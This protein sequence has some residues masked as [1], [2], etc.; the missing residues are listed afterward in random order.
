MLSSSS[1]PC[2]ERWDI[3]KGEEQDL[4]CSNALNAVSLDIRLVA[5]LSSTIRIS[6]SFELYGICA[7]LV[8]SIMISHL[9]ELFPMA[10]VCVTLKGMSHVLVTVNYSCIININA[11]NQINMSQMLID[12][13]DL[14]HNL[15]CLV[16]I[17]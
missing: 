9:Y 6:F 1:L 10:L 12:V 17:K 4:L 7:M 15:L 13:M 2:K 14:S 3:N 5:I 11:L 16:F 8:K